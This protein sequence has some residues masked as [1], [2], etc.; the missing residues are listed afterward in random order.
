MTQGKV[1]LAIPPFSRLLTPHW[2]ACR[3]PPA[4]DEEQLGKPIIRGWNWSK[5]TSSCNN[6]M[7]GEAKKKTAQREKEGGCTGLTVCVCKAR[8]GERGG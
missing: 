3:P 8:E 5:E 1:R 2:V 6:C 7:Q 4:L